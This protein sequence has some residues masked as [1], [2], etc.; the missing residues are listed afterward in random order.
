MIRSAIFIDA[1][2]IYKSFEERNPGAAGNFVKHPHMLITSLE[3]M[4]LGLPIG[5]TARKFI[6][7]RAYAPPHF[8]EEYMKVDDILRNGIEPISS[9]NPSKNNKNSA[10]IKIVLDCVTLLHTHPEIDEY[11][12]LADDTDYSHLSIEL[13]R[14]GKNVIFFAQSPYVKAHARFCD[15]LL[16]ISDLER[17]LKSQS[18]KPSG[19][20]KKAKVGQV[21]PSTQPEMQVAD[22]PTE[23]SPKA[24]QAPDL[25]RALE[26]LAPYADARQG[27]L[28]LQAAMRALVDN[29]E[30]IKE[31]D[32]LGYDGIDSF[33][34]ALASAN[35]N[36][37]YYDRSSGGIRIL[38]E[39]LDLSDWGFSTNDDFTKAV[40]W[41]LVWIDDPI[42][43]FSPKEWQSIFKC[44]HSLSSEFEQG[45]ANLASFAEGFQDSLY[46]LGVHLNLDQAWLIIDSILEEKGTLS[47]YTPET[48]LAYCWRMAIWEQSGQWGWL[49]TQEGADFLVRWFS[50]AGE[51]TEVAAQNL[52]NAM[53]LYSSETIEP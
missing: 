9:A 35:S 15:Y 19:L 12:I 5:S 38:N 36:I 17:F 28:P 20:G 14:K 44:L 25:A 50:V 1:E 31:T 26:V 45:P 46:R 40:R 24:D 16:R 42:P 21:K 51:N 53:T 11:I 41:L 39:R 6:S 33:A 8:F 10:D 18:P 7:K 47:K 32:L 3:K 43:F 23:A 29:I 37:V 34:T 22:A 48:D 30:G 2:N 52:R 13:R 49:N 27:F 4:E